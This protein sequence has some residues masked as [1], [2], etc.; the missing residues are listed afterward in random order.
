MCEARKASNL[1]FWRKV[2]HPLRQKSVG[3]ARF[4]AEKNGFTLIELLV[5]IA[6]IAILAAMLLPALSKARERARQATCMNNLKQINLAIM[7]YVQDYDEWLPPSR[8]HWSSS[9][10]YKWWYQEGSPLWP[11][12]KNE[13]MVYC[14]TKI[15]G[16]RY[17]GMNVH[18]HADLHG[19]YHYWVKFSE[20]RNQNR[21]AD[22]VDGPYPWLGIPN[23]V[24]YNRHSGRANILF[25]DGHVAPHTEESLRAVGAF[26]TRWG[27]EYVRPGPQQQAGW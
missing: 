2:K 26:G 13:N 10:W 15:T 17:Y 7:M 24:D 12:F 3:Q 14:P 6:I 4:L 19:W 8:I 11:Y 9:P 18:V 22:V 21:I 23:E 16:R 20:S 27:V 25:L 5:V 1:P